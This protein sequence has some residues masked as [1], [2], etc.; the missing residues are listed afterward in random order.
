MA[1]PCV[2]GAI[3]T[4]LFYIAPQ[5]IEQCRQYLVISDVFQT[6]F[7]RNDGMS[8]SIHSKVQLALDTAFLLAVLTHLPLTFSVNFEPGG[9]DDQVCHCPLAR[10]SIVDFHRLGPLANAAVIG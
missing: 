7:C 10:Y 4:D 5:R 1:F 9:V 3:A 8:S 2:I 6:A